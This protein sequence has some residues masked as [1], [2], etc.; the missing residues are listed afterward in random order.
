MLAE[1]SCSGFEPQTYL[2]ER[3]KKCFRLRSKHDVENSDNAVNPTKSGKGNSN[4]QQQQ[5][6][7]VTTSISDPQFPEFARLDVAVPQVNDEDTTSCTSYKS[8]SS[9][10][11]SSAKSAESISS[12]QDSKS[13]IT[14]ISESI[15]DDERAITPMESSSVGGSSE[16]TS[17]FI[18]LILKTV[19]NNFDA[20]VMKNEIARLTEE[21]TQLKEERQKWAVRRGKCQNAG[22]ESLIEML[23]ERLAEAENCIQDYRDENTVLK[24][25][26]R[27]LQECDGAEGGNDPENAKLAE[28]LKAS[29]SLCEELMEENET[30]KADVKDLQ[31]EIEEMQVRIVFINYLYFLAC[32][33]FW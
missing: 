11:L 18:K 14:A 30:L 4:G 33:Y 25:E 31:Q 29:E 26:L 16:I 27:E 21:V 22:D 15:Q 5:H 7:S 2:R 32:R 10:G 19:M 17:L 8:A 1:V 12:N 3:C 24:C 9:K 28:K 20:S 13:M 6:T 23:E